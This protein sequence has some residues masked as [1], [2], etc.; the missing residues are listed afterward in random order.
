MP[1]SAT[2]LVIVPLALFFEG[3]LVHAARRQRTPV[4]AL[5]ATVWGLII[6]ASVHDGLVH[7]DRLDFE[8]FYL[9]S[10]A[11]IL[12]SLVM[13]WILLDRFVQALNLVEHGTSTNEAVAA[14]LRECL[15]SLR[16]TVDSLEPT[17][18]DLPGVLGNLRYR[19]AARLR[20]RR[21][22]DAAGVLVSDSL[23]GLGDFLGAQPVPGTTDHYELLLEFVAP[24]TPGTP[25]AFDTYLRALVGS[26]GPVGAD[27][28]AD[29][30]HT[31]HINI[32][33]PE[34]YSL[35][36]ESGVF[37]AGPVPEPRR[38]RYWEAG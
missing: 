34:T 18:A 37:L 12:L 2:R 29:F 25:F 5:L 20:R 8:S 23:Q 17:E 28:I 21:S 1:A 30:S 35:T 13:G 31:A 19:L 6:V 4:S 3:F 38:V 14:E 16:L 15:D 7:R 26:F 22:Y 27:S 32:I 36:S 33:V 10:Y 24:I 9:V 11:M